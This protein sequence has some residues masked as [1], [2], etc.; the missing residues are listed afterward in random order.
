MLIRPS[1]E[2]LKGIGYHLGRL[3]TALGFVMIIPII[4]GL[5]FQ[6]WNPVL[7]FLQIMLGSI[8]LGLFLQRIC[9]TEK[10]INW[11]QGLVVTALSW[12]VAMFIGSIPMYLSGHFLSYLDACFDAMSG[13]ATTGLILIQNLDHASN[14]LNMWRHLIMFI[15]GQGI[16]VIGLT[17]LIRGTAG[18]YRMYVGEAR[19]EKIM[20]NVIQ[21]ARFIWMISLTYLVCGSLLLFLVSILEGM[22]AVRAALHSVWIFMAAFDTGGFTPQSQSILYYHSFPLEIVTMGLMIMGTINFSLHHSIWTGNRREVFKN[23][24]IKTL[25]TTIFLT[26]VLAIFGLYFANAYPNAVAYFRKGFYQIISAHSGTGFMTI[27]AKQFLRE[28]SHLAIFAIILA[29][30]LG[31]SAC[32]TAGG[33]KALRVGVLFKTIIAEVKKLLTP[34]GAV[35]IE[36]I[37]HIKDV[38]LNNRIIRSS[39]LIL[40][41]YII[42]YLV[43]TGVALFYGYS[44][45]EAAFESVSACANVGL[46]IG[47][48]R[49]SMPDFLKMTYIFQMWVGRLE[50][51]TFFAL[52]G[53]IL[54]EIRGK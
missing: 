54:A 2:E 1:F 15:G 48:T 36:K 27:Y 12:I 38:V 21:T 50:F 37:H 13:F 25:S 44:L 7:D 29:M 6:E 46:S 43:G 52:I 20:P 8:I 32:S 22:P 51:M 24:E 28:W 39:M 47:V 10:D 41:L 23:I 35:I 30:G 31:G 42:T 11:T 49:P 19:E 5:I 40:L 14:T 17:F 26:A 4:I 34:G 45:N 3:I 18:A 16:V 33:I 53:F 9:Y